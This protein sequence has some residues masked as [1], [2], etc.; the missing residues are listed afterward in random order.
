MRTLYLDDN[1]VVDL[2]PIKD[3]TWISLL[4]LKGNQIQDLAPLAGYTEQ[5]YTFLEGNPLED[6]STLVEMARA[7][8][9]GDKRFAPYWFLYLAV[10]SLPDAAQAQAEELQQLGV[11]VNQR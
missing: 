9:E 8:V 7:D 6:L 5:R 11:R 1:A 4:G 10:D 2:T 3:L